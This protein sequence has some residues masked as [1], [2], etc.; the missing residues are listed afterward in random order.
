[1]KK[2]IYLCLI[3][4]LILVTKTVSASTI[5]AVCSYPKGQ[6][7]DYFTSNNAKEANFEF[8]ENKDSITAQITF[9]WDDSKEEAVI[10]LPDTASAGSQPNTSKL[11]L[12]YKANDQVTFAGLLKGAP[13]MFSLYPKDKVAV[14]TMHA[15]WGPVI[16][17]GIRATMFHAKCSIDKS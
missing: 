7:V 5:T 16:G 6:R 9:I 13:V 11:S 1:M 12:L 10:V 2:Y 14:Y 17:E 4:F 3:S 8:L 15:T